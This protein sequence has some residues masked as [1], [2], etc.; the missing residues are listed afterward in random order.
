MYERSLQKIGLTSGEAKVYEALLVTGPSTVGPIVKESGVAYSNVYEI[1]QRLIE[2]GI[3]SL[4]TKEKTKHFHAVEPTRLKE[5]VAKQAAAVQQSQNVLKDVLPSLKNL[6]GE[7]SPLHVE[8]FV[9]MKGLKTAYEL[10]VAGGKKGDKGQ[11]VYVYNKKY[12]KA[13]ERFYVDLWKEIRTSPIRWEGICNEEY[14]PTVLGQKKEKTLEQRYVDLP[15]AGNIDLFKDRLLIE[16]W[17]DKPLGILI[18][19]QEVADN[20]RTY[21]DGLWKVSKP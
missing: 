7:A 21:F 11:F 2:K 3:V 20:F 13:T 5:Y 8:V 4:I 18:T 15:L 6:A 10:L 14:R 9:G 12:Y 19:S 16:I 17:A 1:L